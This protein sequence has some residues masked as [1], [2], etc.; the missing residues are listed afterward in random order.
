MRVFLRRHGLYLGV[1]PTAVKGKLGDAAYP[2]Y[3]DRQTGGLWENIEL[4]PHDDGTFDACFVA[5][6]RQLSITPTGSESRPAGGIGGW[7]TL[8]AATQPGDNLSILYRCDGAI[9]VDV[10]TIEAI[11]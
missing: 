4:T 1:D 6:S 2:V 9:M 10:L 3:A 8:R 5:A 7:E 11:A